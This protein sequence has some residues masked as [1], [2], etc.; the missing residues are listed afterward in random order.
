MHASQ[1]AAAVVVAATL[2]AGIGALV[3]LALS[4]LQLTTV[5]VVAL[6]AL[7][8]VAASAV[9]SRSRRWLANPYW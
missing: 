4:A 5:I 1:L 8:V 7:Y 9:G 3:T 2:L 6:A